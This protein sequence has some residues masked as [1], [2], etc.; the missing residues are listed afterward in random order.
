[1]RSVIYLVVALSVAASVAQAQPVPSREPGSTHVFPAGGRRG[2]RVAVRVGTECFPPLSQWT[3]EGSGVTVSGLLSTKV[4][5]QYE[6]SARREPTEVPISYCREWESTVDLSPDAELGQRLWCISSARGGSG[7]RPFMIGDLPE[8]I[9]TEPNSLPQRAERIELPVTVNGQIAGERDLDYYCFAVDVGQWVRCEVVSARLGSPLDPEIQVCDQDGRRLVIT[10]QRIGCDPVVNF[11]APNTGTYT[12][13][14]SNVGQYGGPEYVYR[15]TLS[16]AGNT[17]E[18]AVDESPSNDTSSAATNVSM[19]LAL[20][21]CFE[22]P[23]DEDWFLFAVGKG[24][25]VSIACDPKPAGTPTIPC[26]ELLDARTTSLAKSSGAIGYRRQARLEW[27]SPE[28]STVF[29]RVRDLQQLNRGGPE[30]RYH[31]SVRVNEPGFELRLPADFAN[32][33]PGG[34]LTLEVA[35]LRRGDFDGPIEL[36]AER[37]PPG[38]TAD[39]ASI[40]TNEERGKLVVAAADDARPGQA[41]VKIIGRATLGGQS[42]E[43]VAIAPHLGCDADGVSVES[44]DVADVHLTLQH[45]PVFRLFCAEAYQY[46]H[47]GSVHPYLMEIERLDGFNGPVTLQIGDRQNRDLDGI[48]MMETIIPADATQAI[49]PIYLPEDMHVNVQSQSQL[50]VQGHAVFTDRWGERQSLL[51]VSEKRNI[52]RTLPPVVKLKA[53]DKQ[54]VGH[55]GETLECRFQLERTP[56]FQGAMQIELQQPHAGFF[57]EPKTIDPGATTVVIPVQVADDAPLRSTTLKFVA[58][59]RI[60]SDVP[61][62]SQATVE[63][64]CH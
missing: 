61:L 33:L 62:V 34:K 17:P 7:R 31:L 59:G 1:V 58:R 63:F 16:I 56:L 6:P 39:A 38:V 25:A 43:R 10:E 12:F 55:P 4:H 35:A 29:L 57:S 14:I 13:L 44:A 11:L 9:E 3:M 45:K 54:L 8:F 27:R 24:D 5:P 18:T 46:G 37:L 53:M 21:G 64:I 30:F 47:R 22:R 42:A 41:F 49:M 23:G 15:A 50:Y 48:E 52:I 28:Q 32:V 20:D 51:V 60:N 36:R 40:A 19:P 2:T 26:L